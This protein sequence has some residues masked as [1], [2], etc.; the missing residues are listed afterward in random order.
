M[1]TAWSLGQETTGLLSSSPEFKFPASFALRHRRALL[2]GLHVA[3]LE[4]SGAV[5]RPHGSPHPPRLLPRPGESA[6]AVPEGEGGLG[7]RRHQGNCRRYGLWT[8]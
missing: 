8:N 3:E 1:S 6:V 2:R 4:E 5:H 7:Q